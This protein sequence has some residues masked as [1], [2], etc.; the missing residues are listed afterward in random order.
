[1]TVAGKKAPDPGPMMIGSEPAS[2]TNGTGFRP[3]PKAGTAATR[4][5]C[6]SRGKRGFATG[7]RGS[8]NGD[9]NDRRIQ[10]SVRRQATPGGPERQWLTV[11]HHH[12]GA[13]T[14]PGA[15]PARARA[16]RAPGMQVGRP[17]QDSLRGLVPVSAANRVTGDRSP[18][19]L[20]PRRRRRGWRRRGK[21]LFDLHRARQVEF[22]QAGGTV[23]GRLGGPR[24]IRT[25]EV[26]PQVPIARP[27]R[28]HGSEAGPPLRVGLR[29]EQAL[30][31]RN[32]AAG[33]PRRA[34][35]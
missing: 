25:G 7:V 14:V 17:A 19:L 24:R 10:M 33:Q 23:G 31:R 30:D 12:A 9:G 6:G 29:I 26:A 11:N 2:D 1:M 15:K 20:L 4:L 32:P 34:G 28:L 16:P 35:W 8:E 5:S 22:E 13:A 18:P 3:V 21:L 27:G